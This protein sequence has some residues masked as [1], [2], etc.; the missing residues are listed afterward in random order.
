MVGYADVFESL[1]FVGE[2][3]FAGDVSVVFH[4][5]FRCFHRFFFLFGDG[6]KE[7]FE[8]LDFG[9]KGSKRKL[10]AVDE[11]K[12]AGA[13]CERCRSDAFKEGIYFCCFHR[14]VSAKVFDESNFLFLLFET[15][16]S[17]G[18]S[19]TKLLCVRSQ[20]HVR[21]VLSEKNAIFRARRKHSVGFIHTFGDQV[22]DEHADVC[23]IS[24]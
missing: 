9:R 24:L 3:S 23:F 20:S 11:V 21:V 8:F 18:R 19:Q 14:K 7:F 13:A 12:D 6:I 10:R 5:Y 16:C 2:C 22:V 4:F 17:F 15:L 1:H